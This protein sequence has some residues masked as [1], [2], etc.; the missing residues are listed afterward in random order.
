MTATASNDPWVDD[1]TRVDFTAH[2][3]DRELAELATE[4]LATPTYDP[5]DFEVEDGKPGESLLD[6]LKRVESG[7]PDEV[8]AP[9]PAAE[10]APA[11][12]APVAEP[13]PAD[14]KTVHQY[15][16]GSTLTVEKTSRG[17]KA[18]CD[19]GI[20]GVAPE[21]FYGQTKDE[22]FQNV[23]AGKIN[24]TK[25][26]REQNV[27]LKLEAAPAAPAPSAPAAPAMHELSADDIFEL[28]TKLQSNPALA[29]ETWFQ[30]R[31]GMGVDQLVKLA[32]QGAGAAVELDA[33]GEA[34][35]F[36]AERP[37]YYPG[38]VNNRFNMGARMS[39]KYLQ[40][41]MT[42]RNQVELE[43]RL[44]RGGYWTSENLCEAYDELNEGGL[45]EFAPN[46]SPEPVPV[47][48]P[49]PSA[50]AP[51]AAAAAA[52]SQD[53][54]R[55]VRTVRRPRAGL[56]LSN[57]ETTTV[58]TSHTAE[59]PP[60]ADDLDNL[61]DAQLSELYNSVRRASVTSRR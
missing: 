11:A 12:A 47:S 31:T 61:S 4:P 1:D 45:L 22:L 36:L 23:A 16:D 17:W 20:A 32:Q 41:T 13:A 19:T 29:F 40:T 2:A 56:G 44:I 52:P 33:E 5:K 50:A 28:T 39:A 9:A 15:P 34:K 43:D 6:Y 57:R 37:E 21:I 8:L 58:P 60:S 48:Q 35:D 51:A 46:A 18:T 38:S 54:E 25:K 7:R 24:A 30:K 59:K 42:V 55:I 26:I 53:G 3:E 27:R 10:P 49:T 14:S